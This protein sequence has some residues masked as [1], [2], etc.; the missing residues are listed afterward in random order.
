MLYG[1]FRMTISFAIFC[2]VVMLFASIFVVSYLTTKWLC[3]IAD[4]AMLDKHNKG[5]NKGFKI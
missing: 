4:R 5:Q 2:D 1:M 3:D